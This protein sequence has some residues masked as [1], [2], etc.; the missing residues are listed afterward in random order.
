MFTLEA[1]LPVKEEL[2]AIR[3]EP[4]PKLTRPAACTP[5]VPAAVTSVRTGTPPVTSIG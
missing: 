2:T 4:P 3:L 5:P 1:P